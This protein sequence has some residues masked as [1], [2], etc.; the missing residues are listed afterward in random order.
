MS[1]WKKEIKYCRSCYD[2]LAGYVGVRVTDQL[3]DLHF[4]TRKGD[5]DF[6]LTNIG[7]KFLADN[8]VDVSE[9]KTRKRSFSRGCIDGSEKKPHLAGS[10]GAAFLELM[11]QKQWIER[12]GDSRIIGVTSRG[13]REMREEWKLE[14]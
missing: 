4:L 11:F 5:K 7:S 10:V 9:L 13:R 3:V 14:I 6:E 8:G 2:H 1:V 12:R